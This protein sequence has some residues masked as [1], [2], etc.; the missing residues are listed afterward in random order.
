MAKLIAEPSKP[1]LIEKVVPVLLV[2]S[3]GLAFMVGVLW[4]KVTTLEKGG[5]ATT[6]TAGAAP[7]APAVT[8]EQIKDLFTKNIIKIGDSNRK[9]L[10][11]EVA[12]PSCP[13]CHVAGGHDKELYAQMGVAASYVAPVPELKKLVD[14]GKASFAYIYYPGHGNGEMGAKALYCANEKGKFWEAHDLIMSNAGYNLLNNTVK[15]DKTQSGKIADFLKS[16]I[17]PSDMKSCLDSGKY[18]S[19]LADNTALAATLGI[20][21]TPGFFLNTTS[22]PGAVPFDQ[23]KPAVDA[24]LK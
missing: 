4:Q 14:A 9:L 19:V 2:L 13:W 6:T 17:N 1:S 23:M 5:V 16:V 10:I 24:T 20:S 11:V 15:N 21:G 3:I 18:D 8:L 12:D 7:A 22:Y